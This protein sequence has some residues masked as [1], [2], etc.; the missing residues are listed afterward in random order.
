[1]VIQGMACSEGADPVDISCGQ[2]A[3]FP[4]RDAGRT[5][6]IAANCCR[7]MAVVTPCTHC[8]PVLLCRYRTRRTEG[9]APSYPLCSPC[10]RVE[11]RASG[12]HSG[13][14]SSRL[15]RSV[16]ETGQASIPSPPHS[17]PATAPLARFM[18]KFLRAFLS[19]DER[20]NPSWASADSSG[21][22]SC[23]Q[24][25]EVGAAGAGQG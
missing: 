15:S 19:T 17:L 20:R 16:H 10:A 24:W 18:R 1:M 11:R 3:S 6:H 12:A 5:L 13:L 9:R 23:M 8:R 22:P 7:K 14:H 25:R 21:C 4:A 2:R